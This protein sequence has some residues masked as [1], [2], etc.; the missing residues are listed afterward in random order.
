MLGPRIL[1]MCRCS[2]FGRKTEERGGPEKGDDIGGPP[3]SQHGKKVLAWGDAGWL[4]G[5]RTVRPGLLAAVRGP[6][7][8][9]R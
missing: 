6:T 5:P 2:A 7:E 9:E 4:R 8:G 1:P 3:V